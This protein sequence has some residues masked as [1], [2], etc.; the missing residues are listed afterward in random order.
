MS[1]PQ[2]ATLTI[3]TCFLLILPD[4]MFAQNRELGI[5]L[6]AKPGE[7]SELIPISRNKSLS[8][9]LEEAISK[10]FMDNH[11]I[12]IIDTFLSPLFYST[13]FGVKPGDTLAFYFSPQAPCI[14]KA[15][16]VK[17]ASIDENAPCHKIDLNIVRSNYDASS[18]P[19]DSVEANGWLGD[20]V[21]NTWHSSSFGSYPINWESNHQPLW[22]THYFEVQE[23]LNQWIF[24]NMNLLNSEP[25][26]CFQDRILVLFAPR[27]HL[28]GMMRFQA[29]DATGSPLFYLLKY[30]KDKEPFGNTG[31]YVR[32]YGL[33]FALVVEFMGFPPPMIH[34]VGTYG[35]VLNADPI[36]LK[37]SAS[38][39]CIDTVRCGFDSVYLEYR[40]NDE[41][42]NSIEMVLIEGHKNNGIWEGILPA[43]YI[44]PGDKL[45]FQFAAILK[46]GV[47]ITSAEY[48]FYYFIKESPILVFYND[49]GGSFPS[50]ILHPYY[51]NLWRREVGNVYRYDVWVGSRD[52]PLTK[53]LV[54]MYNFIIQIDASSPATM[55][56]Q[57]IGE[58]MIGG[59]KRGFIWSSQEWGYQL[60]GGT[61]TTFA[62]DDWH[63][64]I[65]GIQTLGPQ[66]INFAVN[67]NPYLP[68]PLK[69]IKNDVVS[70]DLAEFIADSLQLFYNP[71][72]E[73]GFKNWIDAFTPSQD[74][75]VCFT[76]TSE[77]LVFG[78]RKFANN[79]ATVFL[80]FDPLGLD[81][82][83]PGFTPFLD[84]PGYHWTEPNVTSVIGAALRWF[85][86]IW[87]DNIVQPTQLNYLHKYSLSQNYP[88]PFNSDTEIRYQ[89]PEATHVKLEIYNLL[90]QKIRT[91][92]DDPK[93]AGSHTLRWDGRDQY[94]KPV[95]S[96]VYLYRLTAGR[97]CETRKMVVM[98]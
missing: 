19:I 23:P 47:K 75:I 91:L 14:I 83:Y 63:H 64:Q 87:I 97:F 29:G 60:T 77:Q 4:L 98:R 50:W 36:S 66:D 21:H 78:V 10:N 58:W 89:L 53:E 49:D 70:G 7:K 18:H 95:S 12:G 54:D 11:T 92:I 65:L 94:G 74:A 86:G 28:D 25:Q 42:F 48:F 79:I 80:T 43:N 44:E 16:G 32:H 38:S 13:R 9:Q 69:A 76:D 61:D 1:A 59:T 15:V 68:Y 2:K 45:T 52:G 6:P 85:E 34:A 26:L 8:D 71:Y 3:L 30:Y 62:P 81:T 24:I 40:I 88:N 93:P 51:D 20:F 82:A 90:G 33:I 22:G 56:D 67:G 31:W 39:V 55:N 46:T 5:L 27:G 57:V 72:Y 17:I 35:N 37:C 41:E 84:T 73:L 96:G